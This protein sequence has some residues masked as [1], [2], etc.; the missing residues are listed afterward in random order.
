MDVVDG[1]GVATVDMSANYSC[2]GLRS[3]AR[4]L[5]TVY[6]PE[7]ERRGGGL[8]T[9]A[10]F[11]PVERRFEAFMLTP[12][13]VR[14]AMAVIVTATL[15]SVV[16]GGVVITLVDAEEFPDIGT[17]LWWALQTVTTVGYGDVV[18]ENA[19]GQLIGA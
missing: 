1:V 4:P 19:V 14:N 18:P 13:S 3:L 8:R 2:R 16:I 10:S 17:G 5:P 6:K 11:H 7:K 12:L 9:K 15:A